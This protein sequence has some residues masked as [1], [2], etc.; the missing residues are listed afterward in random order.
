MKKESEHHDM[1]FGV[2][3][4]PNLVCPDTLFFLDPFCSLGVG[5]TFTTVAFPSRRGTRKKI[6]EYRISNIKIPNS[7]TLLPNTTAMP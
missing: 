2:R 7:G 5:G 1:W 6:I 3:S 4:R